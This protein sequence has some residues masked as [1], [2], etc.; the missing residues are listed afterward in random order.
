MLTGAAIYLYAMDVLVNVSTAIPTQVYFPLHSV[1]SYYY[2]I[3]NYYLP[4]LTANIHNGKKRVKV[5]RKE[6]K[7][8]VVP[9]LNYLNTTP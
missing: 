5:T 4:T 7:G 6:L 8:K 1:P 2:S 3:R 9:V